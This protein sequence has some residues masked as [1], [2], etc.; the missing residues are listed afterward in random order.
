MLTGP[1]AP[2]VKIKT[3]YTPRKFQKVLHSHL[4]RFNVLVCHRRFGK[5]VFSICELI[6]RALNNPLRNPN[7]AYIAPTYKQ[8]KKIAWQYFLDYTR[9]LPGVKANKSDLTVYIE[10]PGR[11]D[12]GTGE[13]DPDVITLTLLGADDPDSI[14]GIY[15]DGCIIDEYAQCDPIIWGQVIRPALA[16]RKKIARDLGLYYDLSGTPLE[17]WAI[18]IG[19]PK[20]QNHFH[21]IFQTA[22]AHEQYCNEYERSVDV[23]SEW[24]YWDE[25]EARC[26]IDSDT[27]EKERNKI[28]AGWPV[29]KV[30]RYK[31]FRKYVVG[32]AWYAALYKASETGVL[33]QDEIDEMRETLTPNEIDQ[34]LECDFNAAVLG[35]Y[36][37]HI[38]VDLKNQGDIS[39]DI[40]FNPKY[41]VDTHWDIGVGDK[42]TIWFSQKI[43]TKAVHYVDY[44]EFDGKGIE[45]YISVLDAKAGAKG[46]RRE[47]DPGVWIEGEG[48]KYGRHTWPHD[49]SVKEWGTGQTRQ[50]TARSLGLIVDIQPKQSIDDRIQASRN[51]L[52]ISKFN[53]KKCFRGLEC[54]Y[55]YQ[56]IWDDKLMMFQNKPKHDWSS[57][58]ADSFGYSALDDRPSNFTSSYGN[59]KGRQTH[60]DDDYDEFAG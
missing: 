24:D 3:G 45:F 41:P 25:E 56:K 60:A 33:D 36:Y 53:G 6:D 8:A 21:R 20:G 46:T 1:S 35:S 49:G 32:S 29:E 43:G 15:L 55:N 18:F 13:V 37:G 42:A 2:P 10:R 22:E 40:R 17:P 26:G 54:L 58:G 14:R 30:E 9:F 57:H 48:Y 5:T 51:R 44:F 11:I 27:S 28:F 38:M 16:D 4:R 12:P 19:T 59:W 47:V 39:D 34:E 50:E 31:K 23:E 7:Y 52:K